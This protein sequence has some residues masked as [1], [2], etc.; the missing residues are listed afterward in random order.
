MDVQVTI[1]ATIHALLVLLLLVMIVAP[2]AI[3]AA[4]AAAEP[5]PCV[6]APLPPAALAQA[7]RFEPAESAAPAAQR[8]VGA[9]TRVVQP[10]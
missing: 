4:H 3:N 8:P 2:L 5:C 1:L 9:Q 10:I 7:D 6:H